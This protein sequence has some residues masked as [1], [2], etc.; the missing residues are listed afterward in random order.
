M[1]G[2]ASLEPEYFE[3]MFKGDEDPWNLETSSYEQTKFACTMAALGTRVY[4]KGFEV[5]CAKGVLTSKLAAVCRSLLAIDVS[6][7][8]LR[9]AQQRCVSLPHVSFANM[10]FPRNAPLET[11]DLV[12][13]SEVAYYW[14]DHDLERAAAWI[15]EHLAPGG[16]L[17]LVHWTGETDYPQTG[18]EAVSKLKSALSHTVNVVCDQRLDQYRLDLWCKRL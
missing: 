8:A 1:S 2:S 6:D 11:F 4:D 10:M 5:G 17:L 18:D 13:L 12:L 15:A 14:D 7:T 9:A 3:E 16:H